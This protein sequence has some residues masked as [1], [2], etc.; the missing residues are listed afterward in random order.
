M[1]RPGEISVPLDAAAMAEE[2][3]ID[4]ARKREIL[5]LEARC[6]AA[7]PFSI[8]GVRRGAAPAEV[9]KAYYELTRRFHPDRFFGKN[10]G[11]FKTRIDKIFRRLTEAQELLCNPA[12]L[13]AYI[14]RHPE[15]VFPAEPT[16]AVEQSH[17]SER[18]ARL[19]R[20]PYLA[21]Q[22]KLHELAVAGRRFLEKGD[23]ARAY[24]ELNLALQVDPKNKE[25]AQM[26]QAAKRGADAQRAAAEHKLGVQAESLGNGA[27]ALS[28]FRL[29]I[30]LDPENTEYAF[31]AARQLLHSGGDSELK[32]AHVLARRAAEREPDKIEHR[33]LFAKVLL[34]AGLE[35]NAARE[36]EAVLELRPGEPY[37]KD[38]LRKLKWKL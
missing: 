37:A 23:F 15:L 35:K 28:H 22:A 11:S 7:D 36:L 13:Q 31:R 14:A 33:L 3:E 8:I 19:A 26:V 18:R 21:K 34:R 2:V 5:Q 9:K 32:Q 4:Q 38:Q 6:A 24:S 30:S 12:K 1:S 16:P 10:I 20:H 25:I 27:E 29:A 17:A